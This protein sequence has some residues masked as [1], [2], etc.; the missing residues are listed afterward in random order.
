MINM[1]YQVIQTALNDQRSTQLECKRYDAY[2]ALKE[3]NEDV[4]VEGKQLNHFIHQKVG[5][6]LILN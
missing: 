1:D 4:C 6:N 3:L 2:T 5:P